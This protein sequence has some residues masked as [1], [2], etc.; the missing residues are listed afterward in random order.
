MNPAWP[1]A[2]RLVPNSHALPSKLAVLSHLVTT[3]T[4]ADH[5][6]EAMI[7]ARQK[8][9]KQA[10]LLR[11]LLRVYPL[12]SVQVPPKGQSNVL[13]AKGTAALFRVATTKVNVDHA[14]R[15]DNVLVTGI[16]KESVK[17]TPMPS[18]LRWLVPL[19]SV[20][21]AIPRLGPKVLPRCHRRWQAAKPP[22]QHQSFPPGPSQN[23]RW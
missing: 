6:P 14:I 2:L 1:I 3:E 5:E 16:R 4:E 8:I 23:K 19:I 21:A 20:Q 18:L 7:L 11:Q 10:L 12:T 17:L 15:Q 13:P 22:R 9:Y